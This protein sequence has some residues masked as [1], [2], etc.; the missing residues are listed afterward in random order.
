[1]MNSDKLHSSANNVEAL[2]QLI[3]ARL[4]PSADRLPHDI[5]ERLRAARLQAV[6]K[7]KL[8]LRQGATVW[9]PQSHSGALSVGQAGGPSSWWNRL[10]AVGLLLVLAVGLLLINVVQDDIGTRELADIDAALLTDDL[11]PTAY[12]DAGFAQFLKVGYRQDPS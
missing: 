12:V 3:A 5:T 8:L 7:R 10:G 1:M 11:P 6:E 9:L 4:A 2:G